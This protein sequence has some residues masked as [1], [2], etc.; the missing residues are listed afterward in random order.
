MRRRSALRVRAA[1]LLR[2]ACV[3]DAAEEH[4]ESGFRV[5]C[6][7]LGKCLV[8][9]VECATLAALCATCR[10]ARAALAGVTAARG[11]CVCRLAYALWARAAIR[12][13]LRPSARLDDYVRCEL[14]TERFGGEKLAEVK[15]ARVVNPSAHLALAD[16]EPQT[17]TAVALWRCAAPW[18]TGTPRQAQ[19]PRLLSEAAAGRALTQ[20]LIAGFTPLRRRGFYNACD[21]ETPL[22]GRP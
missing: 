7:H 8:G 13:L 3:E 17:P 21:A 10:H 4:S 5:L 16:G 22:W 12:W 1:A 19:A 2:M 15:F 18:P 20:L 6:A 11:R 9:R 14:L